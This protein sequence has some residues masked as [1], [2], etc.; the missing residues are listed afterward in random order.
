MRVKT[1]TYLVL[2]IILS[3]SV[4]A[5]GI[6]TQY[7]EENT[8]KLYPGQNYYYRLG[9]QNKEEESVLVRIDLES[10]IA[11]LAGGPEVHIPAKTYEGVN[12]Y[13]NITV[14]ATAQVGDTYNINYLAAPV[15]EGEG[16]IPL[17]VRY[18]RTFRV[19][20]VEKPAGI[21]EQ[22]PA[23]LP[24][25][26]QQK[27]GILKWILF[28]IILIIIIVVAILLWNKSHQISGRLMKKEQGISLKHTESEIKPFQTIKH[29]PEPVVTMQMPI[30]RPK[31]EAKPLDQPVQKPMPIKQEKIISQHHYFHLRNGKSLK[32]LEELYSELKNMNNEEFTHHVNHSKNDFAN[33][34]LHILEKPALASQL[35]KTTAKHETLELIKNELDQR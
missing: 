31:T 25:D 21:E 23:Q 12:V 20:V 15:K 3:M 11:T 14:P 5:F 26:L 4:S 35:F 2:A 1:L 30:I 33:W 18:D 6:S 29:E 22:Q 32:N 28:P 24:S 13:F 7:M 9:L 34:V 19:L 17:S 27:P 16:Q 10:S 8:L